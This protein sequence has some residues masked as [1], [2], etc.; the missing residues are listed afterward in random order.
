MKWSFLDLLFPSRCVVCDGLTDCPGEKVCRKCKNQIV[1]IHD[2]YCLKC[3]KQLGQE[4][5]EYCNDCERIRHL[6]VQGTA[7]YDYGSMADSV[8]RFKYGGRAEYA[9]FYGRDLYEKKAEWLAGIRP[10]ALVPVPVHSSRMRSR[11][12]NQAYLIARELSRHC[13]IPVRNNLIGRTRRTKPLKN[14]SHEER[15]NNLKKAFKI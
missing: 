8:F 5:K 9:A 4:E 10:D 3:G 15:Q 6:Y 11:G 13:G 1:Y 7:L 14:L 12:Y 2:P